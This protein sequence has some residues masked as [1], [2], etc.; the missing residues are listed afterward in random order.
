MVTQTDIIF[1]NNIREAF[2]SMADEVEYA[3]ILWVRNL[4]EVLNKI[5]SYSVFDGEVDDSHWK[6]IPETDNP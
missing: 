5:F 4:E 3:S 2:T 1:Y 6:S